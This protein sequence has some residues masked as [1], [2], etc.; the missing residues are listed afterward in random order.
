ME[1]QALL[2]LI[3]LLASDLMNSSAVVIDNGSRTLR[4]GFAV[5]EDPRISFTS[6]VGR[7]KYQHVMS[8]TNTSCRPSLAGLLHTHVVCLCSCLLWLLQDFLDSSHQD[9]YVGDEV[10][11]RRG[12][13]KLSYPVHRGIVQKWDD[14]ERVWH[15]TFRRLGVAADKQPLLLTEAPLNPGANRERMTQVMFE[16]FDAPVR[17]RLLG[18]SSIA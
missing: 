9:A 7:P 1:Q 15:C 5:D 3:S 6:V 8:S 17:W 14:M 13:L 11:P 18:R 2:V 16:T 10:R 12:V 4:A